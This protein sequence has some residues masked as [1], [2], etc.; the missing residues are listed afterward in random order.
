M[1]NVLIGLGLLVTAAGAVTISAQHTSR[2]H[3]AALNPGHMM[4]LHACAAG[5]GKTSGDAVADH[6][7]VLA[8]KLDLTADQ[9]ANVTR[10]ASEA[11]ASMAKYHEEILS[12]LTPEQ[13]EK[14]KDMH[15]GDDSGIHALFKKLHGGR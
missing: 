15:R 7:S 13:R 8:T 10:L 1:R 14:L 12:T 11:C 3:Q 6:M 5:P 9:R 2:D 4:A